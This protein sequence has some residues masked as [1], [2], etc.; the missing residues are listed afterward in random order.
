MKSIVMLLLLAIVTS[1]CGNGAHKKDGMQQSQETIM[2]ETTVQE[3]TVQE[4]STLQEITSEHLKK[5]D[6]KAGVANETGVQNNAEVNRLNN[7]LLREYKNLLLFDYSL[8]SAD[9]DISQFAIIDVNSDGIYE[10][11]V[12]VSRENAAKS[13]TVLYYYDLKN[14]EISEYEDSYYAHFLKMENGQFAS[15]T[16]HMSE[17]IEILEMK[18]GEVVITEELGV[19][20]HWFDEKVLL[21][22]ESQIQKEQELQR[23]HEY[24]RFQKYYADLQPATLENI[25]HYLEYD[26]H[27]M[28][29]ETNG[30]SALIEED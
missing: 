22:R 2:E 4:S 23:I 18:E 3:T 26:V 17:R 9:G 29:G 12:Q 14:D 28:V 27:E 10:L 15:V 5:N 11:V 19:D 1:G 21:D 20:P 8:K 24:D 13:S 25:R 7:N 30:L 6:S 16:Y